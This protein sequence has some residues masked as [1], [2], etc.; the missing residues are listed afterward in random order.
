MSKDKTNE[1]V[2]FQSATTV[3]VQFVEI[4]DDYQARQQDDPNFDPRTAIYDL[5]DDLV[6]IYEKAKDNE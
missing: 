3:G 4:M 6:F 5:Y 1:V 2:F